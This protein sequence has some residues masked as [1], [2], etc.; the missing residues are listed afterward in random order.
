MCLPHVYLPTYVRIYK[1]HKPTLTTIQVQGI[2][3]RHSLCGQNSKP[4]H[5]VCMCSLPVATCQ[6]LCLC[7]VRVCVGCVWSSASM[8]V[9]VMYS[10]FLHDFTGN[11][12]IT[13]VMYEGMCITCPRGGRGGVRGVL[14]GYLTLVP[15][16]WL[17]HTRA[18]KQLLP[19]SVLLG[20]PHWG[21]L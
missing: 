20:A 3:L 7:C 4:L 9:I 12:L 1:M 16:L 17:Q 6:I 14:C 11:G 2:P 19:Q 5:P 8:S 10:S 21:L 15:L 18:A 13:C